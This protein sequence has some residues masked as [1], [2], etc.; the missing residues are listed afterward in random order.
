MWL[1]IHVSEW[2]ASVPG[3]CFH[4]RSPTALT[5]LLYYGT[6]IGLTS[7]WFTKPRV[8]GWALAALGLV[9]VAWLAQWYRDRGASTL[10]VVPLGGGSAVYASDA[11]KDMLVDCGG[12]VAAEFTL[13][14][15]LRSQGVNH[16]DHVVLTH[17]DVRQI[18]GAELILRTF[19]PGRVLTSPIQFRSPNYRRLL[20]VPLLDRTR[21]QAIRA[22]DNAGSWSVLHPEAADRFT[23]ADD[24][25]LVLL[26]EIQGVRVLLL[27]DLG[28]KGQEALLA[29]KPALRADIV[30]AGLPT[31][32]EPLATGLLNALHPAVVVIADSEYP[33]TRRA[34]PRL[35]ERLARAQ[36]PVVFT[37]E[38]GAVRIEFRRGLWELRSMS[39]QRLAGGAS[40]ARDTPPDETQ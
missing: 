33:A 27:S 29:R 11:G 16:L 9:A 19:S 4:V 23:Q 14:P 10:T 12:S 6:V 34:N 24:S 20:A 25:A 39:G 5:C 1:M 21:W 37:R 31:T 15:F 22:G 28:R 32:G 30:V 40:S 8:R 2:S 26:G 36:V 17:G 3:G 35:R 13:R 7:G 38:T 18:G